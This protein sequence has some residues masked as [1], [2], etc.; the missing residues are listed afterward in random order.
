MQ[1]PQRYQIKGF[2][3]EDITHVRRINQI[4]YAN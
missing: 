2:K 4:S 3:L 1:S